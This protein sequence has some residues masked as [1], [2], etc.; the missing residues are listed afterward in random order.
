MD[1][2]EQTT[3]E[4][5][6]EGATEVDVVAELKGFVEGLAASF[7]EK[8]DAMNRKYDDL[9]HTLAREVSDGDVDEP[10]DWSWEALRET[11]FP[12]VV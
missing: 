10:Q 6:T 7:T 2:E 1:G 9:R 5:V 4:S 11:M 12:R 3:G 8:V